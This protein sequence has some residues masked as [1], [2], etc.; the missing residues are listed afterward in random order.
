MRDRSE[1][2]KAADGGVAGAD[3]DVSA[4]SHHMIE[5]SAPFR[6]YSQH[7]DSLSDFIPYTLYFTSVFEFGYCVKG[8]YHHAMKTGG[9]LVISP[10]AG[11]SGNASAFVFIFVR[12]A[13][14][15]ADATR[16]ARDSFDRGLARRCAPSP[17]SLNVFS[18]KAC[19]MLGGEKCS[20]PIPIMPS[21]II[22][23][24]SLLLCLKGQSICLMAELHTPQW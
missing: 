23:I 5:K 7:R 21:S 3:A 2:M 19:S 13:F 20:I 15:L 8:S 14:S 10:T 16:S 17:S 24:F 18:S 1:V 11:I 6:R 22:F 9:I 4:D 12:R